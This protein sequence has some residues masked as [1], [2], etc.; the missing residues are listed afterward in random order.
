MINVS[1]YKVVHGEKVLN[2]LTI[3]SYEFDGEQYNFETRNTT[4]KAKFL[5]VIAIN[6]DGNVV[7]IYDEAWN[8]RKPME[9]IVERL[10]DLAKTH[11][12]IGFKYECEAFGENSQYYS[13]QADR[14]Y[15]KQI[16]YLNAIE[17]VN[18]EGGLI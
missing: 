1:N 8:T 7:S 15:S 14:N 16:A 2:A 18:E 9:R 10:E 5:E 17:I 3:N 4:V 13:N 6:E 11:E 12:N